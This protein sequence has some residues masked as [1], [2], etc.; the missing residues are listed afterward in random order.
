MKIQDRA[1]SWDEHLATWR[2]EQGDHVTLIGPTKAGKTTL[3][4]AIL[5]LRDYVVVLSAKPR[6]STLEAYANEH[7]YRI[8]RRWGDVGMPRRGGDRVLLWPKASDPEDFEARQ[9]AEFRACLSDVFQVGGWTV[10]VDELSYVTD[11]LQL[12]RPLTRLW[13][14]GR[15]LGVTVVASTQAPVYVP[16]HAYDQVVHMYLWRTRDLDRVRRLAEISGAVD[17]RR[18]FEELRALEEHQCLYVDGATGET[19]RTMV[20]AD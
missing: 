15:S 1:L 17:P 19:R 5:P 7:G 11:Y 6:D 4:G 14:Q 9:Y 3:A 8:V 16:R 13:A 20:D 18:L 2:W 10:Y 12:T